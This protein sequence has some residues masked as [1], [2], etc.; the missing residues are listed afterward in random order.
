LPG[1]FKRMLASRAGT[2]KAKERKG[3]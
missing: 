2:Q 1:D 3:T